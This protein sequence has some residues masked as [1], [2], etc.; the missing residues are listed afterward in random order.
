M[1]EDELDTRDDQK[2]DSPKDKS[3]FFSFW[4]ENRF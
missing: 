2:D 3:K 1:S 4:K